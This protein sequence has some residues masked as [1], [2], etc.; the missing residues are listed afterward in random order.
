MLERNALFI[1]LCMIISVAVGEISIG[2]IINSIAVISDGTHALFDAIIIA[3]LLFMLRFS[4]KPRDLEH[5]YG[6]GRLETIA[7]LIGGIILFII[8]VIII[9]EAIG[10]LFEHVTIS[11]QIGIYVVIYALIIALFRIIVFKTTNTH[12]RSISI[13]LYDSIADLGSSLS[14]LI[15]LLLVNY[16]INIADSIASLFLATM[17][18]YLTTRLT[19]SSIMELTDAIDPILVKKTR[20]II[21]SIEGVRECKDLRMR[22]VGREILVDT[23]LTLDSNISFVKAH[24]I[25]SKIEEKIKSGINASI[26]MVHFEP[27]KYTEMENVIRDIAM[28]I[29]GV[30]NIHNIMISDTKDGKI[31]SMHIQV[32]R[33]LSLIKA[34]A[35]SDEVEREVKNRI[36]AS[37]VTIHIEPSIREMKEVRRIEE[38][39]IRDVIRDI[40]KEEKI[41]I[42]RLDMYEV[43]RIIRIDINCSMNDDASIEEV[44]EI[45]TKFERRIRDRFNA[46]VNIHTEP[47]NVNQL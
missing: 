4:V 42:N 18:L 37:S 11:N 34:H 38:P 15:A 32:D 41:K 12:S 40:A 28:D 44:H 10:R 6:H 17:L 29:A 5:T 7:V 19:Y 24:T 25:S 26:V 3:L 9:M 8:S 16:G 27:E 2:I 20:D 36:R 43:N 47:S 23:I 33:K 39:N 21:M 30:K 13:G 1:S 31:I 14:A 35:I 46:I 45:V 22:R